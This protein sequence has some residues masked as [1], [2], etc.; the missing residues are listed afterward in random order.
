MRASQTGRLAIRP[1]R[2]WLSVSL[3][4]PDD[5]HQKKPKYENTEERDSHLKSQKP[6]KNQ[7]MKM[8]KKKERLAY[9]EKEYQKTKYENTKERETTQ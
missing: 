6:S 3:L 7:N 9:T 5:D 8:Q 1:K 4:Q 2:V